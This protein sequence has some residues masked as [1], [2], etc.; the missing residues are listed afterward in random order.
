VN[1]LGNVPAGTLPARL[2]SSQP[3]CT[4]VNSSPL[5]LSDADARTVYLLEALQTQRTF[6]REHFSRLRSWVERK[7]EKCSC[8]NTVENFGRLCCILQHNAINSHFF[9]LTSHKFTLF[10]YF[11]V[12]NSTYSRGSPGNCLLLAGGY[13]DHAGSRSGD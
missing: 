3:K 1:S 6:L 13:G 5:K 12:F 7:A 2:G 8:R 10:H 9:I 4:A 11:C